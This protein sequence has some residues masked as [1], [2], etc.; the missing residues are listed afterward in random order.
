MKNISFLVFVMSVFIS[1][2]TLCNKVDL[3]IFSFDRPLQL[4]S[5]LES[6]KKYV[7]NIN[8]IELIYRTSSEKYEQA[9]RDIAKEFSDVRFKKQI[10]GE[11]V[12]N[13]RELTLEAIS[14]SQG[15]YVVFL[16]DDIIVKDYTDFNECVYY[17]EKTKAYAFYLKMGSHLTQCYSHKPNNQ[18]SEQDQVGW[19]YSSDYSQPVP[20]HDRV[21]KDIYSWDFSDGIH[22]WNYPNSVDM[23]LYRKSDI[24][25]V[26]LSLDFNSPNTL[27]QFW[28]TKYPDNKIGLFYNISKCI[29]IPMNRVQDEH[30]N[31]HMNLYSLD[32]L[33]K[34]FNDGLK[35]DIRPLFKVLNNDVHWEYDPKFI[36]R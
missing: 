23:V 26:L 33:L 25:H 15:D 36:T 27:E 22:D 21:D 11:S 3:I 31:N 7:K 24:Y 10:V 17:L 16:V 30:L 14:S 13:F 4:Y 12:N 32:E 28:A 2:N 9:Y 34:K 1:S 19:G 5:L 8:N 6:T 35:I 29:N 18:L 20:Q